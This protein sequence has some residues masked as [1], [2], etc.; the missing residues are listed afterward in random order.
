MKPQLP[1]LLLGVGTLSK[2][3]TALAFGADAVYC[4]AAGLSMRPDAS[5]FGP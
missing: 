4:G 1:E 2:L 3:R 5:S